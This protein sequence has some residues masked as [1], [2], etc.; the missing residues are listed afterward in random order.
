MNSVQLPHAWACMIDT[1]TKHNGKARDG[2][3]DR[4]LERTPKSSSLW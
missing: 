3:P 4:A 1:K 2:K